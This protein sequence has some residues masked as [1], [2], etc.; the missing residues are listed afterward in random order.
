MKKLILT[1]S[2][3]A[4]F[5]TVSQAQVLISL[6]L[7]DKLNSEKLEFGLI[8][9]ASF[10]NTTGF[11]SAEL[12][13]SETNQKVL[14][15]WHLGFYFDIMMDDRWSFTP[16]VLVVSTMGAGNLT[17]YD[18][19]D[20]DV[21]NA[22]EG[23][24]ISREIGYFQV[25]LMM[26]YKVWPKIFLSAGPQVALRNKAYDIFE[27]EQLSDE[28]DLFLKRDIRDEILWIDAGITAGAGYKFRK[29]GKSMAAGFK[30]Y[31]G[32]LD[33]E[34]SNLGDPVRNT[35]WYA[36]VTIPIGAGKGVKNAKTNQS[37]V[38]E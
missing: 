7:G 19:G 4:G 26:K 29:H 17:V 37:N 28:P 24:S 30:Y 9:G 25:P 5:S 14:P 10:S 6:L 35:A 13:Q 34:K 32:L 2:I 21:D 22:F 12:G 38:T 3:V 23:G 11:Y 16:A 31:Q 36:Y 20:E 27:K 18:I 8:G 15:N 1:L 33:I